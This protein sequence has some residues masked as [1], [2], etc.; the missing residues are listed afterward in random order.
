M[1]LTAHQPVYLPW[2]GLFHKVALS[3]EF[4]IFDDVQY[5][6]KDWN[7][8]NRIKTNTGALMLTVPVLTKGHREKPIRA[9][10]IN[11]AID[12][13]K[14]H[15]MSIIAAYKKAPYFDKYAGFFEDLYSREWNYLTHIND[16]IFLYLLDMFGI[17]VTIHRASEKK[18]EGT[19]SSLVLDMCKKL[20]AST[21][22]FGALGKDYARVE[23]FAHE[24]VKV[25]FQDYVH[26]KYPQLHGEFVP[27][28][29]V[30]DLLFNCGKAGLDILMSGNVTKQE[31]E[32]S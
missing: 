6:K 1:I 29:S 24:G 18:F 20:G 8:R 28:M 21:Y 22:I 31:I 14:K 27:Y 19:K 15:W 12:W 5:L 16:Y 11:N 25:F 4:C 30:I 17:K 7:N 26:P 10:E 2:L 9:L 23:E 13:R 32:K 3:D